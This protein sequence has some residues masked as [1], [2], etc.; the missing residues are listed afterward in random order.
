MKGLQQLEPINIDRLSDWEKETFE[1]F[2]KKMKDREQLFPC[3]PATQGF[4]LNH[5]RYGFLPDPRNEEAK[6]QLRKLLAE[7]TESSNEFGDYTSLIIFFNTPEV[8]KETY[9]VEQFEEIFWNQ[10]NDLASHDEKE[11][12]AHIPSNPEETL[13]EFCFH[14]EQYFM[15]CGTPAHR[16]RKSRHFDEYMLAITPRWVLTKFGESPK[17][18]EKIRKQVRKRIEKYDSV[19]IHPEL[20][21][22]GNEDNFEWKQY[23]LHDDDSALSKCPFH[24]MLKNEKEK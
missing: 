22:Y 12:P 11:W 5:L 10:M 16:N 20:N 2:A 23:F 3:I 9:T 7:Y 18:A 13:W 24:R 1:K 15:Y 4:A 8:L 17:Y 21:S 19:P 6:I 14:G